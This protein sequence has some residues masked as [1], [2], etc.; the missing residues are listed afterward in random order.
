[1]TFTCL[2]IILFVCWNISETLKRGISERDRVPWIQE[3]GGR[4]EREGEVEARRVLKEFIKESRGRGEGVGQQ[5][6]GQRE[7]GG[8]RVEG[9]ST[10]EEEVEVIMRYLQ[11]RRGGREEEEDK[12]VI[13]KFFNQAKRVDKEDKGEGRGEG[14]E[15][16]GEAKN[17]EGLEKEK[18]GKGAGEGCNKEDDDDRR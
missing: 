14:K 5:V 2:H 15:D 10:E 8:K 16:E 1:M 9:Q 17:T 7:E 3:E 4:R 6:E 13:L 11:E 12:Q 18:E